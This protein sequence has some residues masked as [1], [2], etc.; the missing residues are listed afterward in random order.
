MKKRHD[1]SNTEN[2]TET[3]GSAHHHHS[4]SFYHTI[5]H[6][7]RSLSNQTQLVPFQKFSFFRW[8]VNVDMNVV[9]FKHKLIVK[10]YKTLLLFR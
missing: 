1:H 5:P 7:E 4:N 6:F 9:F 2:H 3:P 10:K 8:E